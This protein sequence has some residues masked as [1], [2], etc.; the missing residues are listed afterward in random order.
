MLSAMLMQTVPTKRESMM[1]EVT[2]IKDTKYT[3]AA[4]GCAFEWYGHNRPSKTS[5]LSVLQYL[6]KG[7]ME[8]YDQ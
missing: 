6:V 1:K 2:M 4:R 5:D 8:R 3:A 7:R